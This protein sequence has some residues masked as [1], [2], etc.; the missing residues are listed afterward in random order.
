MI[1]DRKILHSMILFEILVFETFCR[2][3]DDNTEVWVIG[4]F[5]IVFPCDWFIELADYK[6][7]DKEA[8]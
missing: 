8:N 3:Y 4:S 7:S 1:N 6:L 5:K 2:C